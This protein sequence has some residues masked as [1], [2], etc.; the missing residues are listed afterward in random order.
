MK[1]KLLLLPLFLLVLA[2]CGPSTSSEPDSTPGTSQPGTSQPGTSVTSEED[3]LPPPPS[4]SEEP[5]PDSMTISQIRDIPLNATGGLDAGQI[6]EV[7]TSGTVTNVARRASGNTYNVTIQDGEEA[8]LL[9]AITEAKIAEFGVPG[10]LLTVDGTLAPYKGLWEL[11]GVKVVTKTAGTAVT[12]KTLTSVAQAGLVGLDSV[13]V[14]IEGLSYVSGEVVADTSADNLMFK[15][16]AD[17]IAGY[18][19]YAIPT[20]IQAAIAAALVP[21]GDA[22]GKIDIMDTLTFTGILDMNAGTY[23]LAITGAD[24]FT[25]VTDGGE[26]VAPTEYLDMIELRAAIKAGTKKAGDVVDFEGVVVAKDNFS[27]SFGNGEVIIQTTNGADAAGIFMYRVP[28]AKYDAVAVGNLIRGSATIGAYSGLDQLVAPFGDF[29][30][31]EAVGP[32]QSPVELTETLLADANFVDKTGT[33]VTAT[34][35]TAAADVVVTAGSDITVTLGKG[36]QTVDLFANK[37]YADHADVVAKLNLIKAGYTVE[38]QKGAAWLG[39]KTTERVML[40]DADKI[41]VRDTLGEIVGGPVDPVSQTI[42]TLDF[43]KASAQVST[44]KPEADFYSYAGTYTIG[45]T[46]GTTTQSWTV[47][48]YNPNNW[49]VAA[50]RFGGKNSQPTAATLTGKPAGITDTLHIG[51]ATSTTPIVGTI[52]RVEI[53]TLAKFG[54]PANSVQEKA[55]LQASTSAD[56]S[57][58]VVDLGAVQI[59]ENTTLVFDLATAQTDMHFRVV[60]AQTFTSS[61]NAGILVASIA[62]RSMVA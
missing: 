16:G 2:A 6:K 1:K 19:H 38:L 45:M 23:Q 21:T 62:F 57:A 47:L 56:F 26:P 11:S 52:N 27:A 28:T 58:G 50:S 37:Y 13:L 36:A 15:L 48:G 39:W 32:T 33:L 34:G 41:I 3:S 55:Y 5:A 25:N 46:D 35:L 24:N 59:A 60:F 8:M 31:V 10:D 18:L 53:V 29:T 54:T 30:V 9:Y 61:S 14:K 22:D 42:Y 40:L 12:P 49:A 17:N 43:S 20:D 51:Y 4:S 44:S 7:R